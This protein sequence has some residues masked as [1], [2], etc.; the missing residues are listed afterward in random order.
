MN[1]QYKVKP[2]DKYKLTCWLFQQTIMK[3]CRNVSKKELHTHHIKPKAKYPK[4][5][6][7]Y[8]NMVEV[9]PILHAVLHHWLHNAYLEAGNMEDARRFDVAK[10]ILDYMNKS[11]ERYCIAA[12]DLDA[13]ADFWWPSIVT[14]AE[15]VIHM[16]T[17]NVDIFAL[18]KNLKYYTEKRKTNRLTIEEAQELIEYADF[19]VQ[20]CCDVWKKTGETFEKWGKVKAD[21]LDYSIEDI[22]NIIKESQAEILDSS[23]LI[24]FAQLAQDIDSI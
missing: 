18:K 11:A 19:T 24:D 22:S 17:T 10:N 23:E 16:P 5:E 1:T 8:Y 20:R 4:L 12:D 7:D 15:L 14:A 13:I 3:H 6:N 2:I 9:P 21:G